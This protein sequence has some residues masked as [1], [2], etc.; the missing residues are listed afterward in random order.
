VARPFP[1]LNG[2]TSAALLHEFSLN[3]IFRTH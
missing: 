2:V 1:M 3:F